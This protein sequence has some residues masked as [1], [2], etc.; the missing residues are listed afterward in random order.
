MP[1]KGIHPEYHE[2]TIETFNEDGSK[3]TFKSASTFKG[4]VLASEVNIHKH[5]AWKDDSK[6]KKLQNNIINSFT[7]TFI[8][9]L[10]KLILLNKTLL[11]LFKNM[12]YLF[13]FEYSNFLSLQFFH[14]FVLFIIQR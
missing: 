14:L 12:P 2:I 5:P 3:K 4:D 7:F 13:F 10:F 11:F 8:V 6:V 9:L 1:K